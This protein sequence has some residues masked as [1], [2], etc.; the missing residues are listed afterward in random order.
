MD[1]VIEKPVP[2]APVVPK[3]VRDNV[4]PVSAEDKRPAHLAAWFDAKDEEGRKAA[5]GKHPKLKE[6]FSEAGKY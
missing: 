5:V 4:A 1:D 2:S 6:I 3:E